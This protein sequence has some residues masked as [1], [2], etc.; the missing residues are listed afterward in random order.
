MFL[1]T[2]NVVFREHRSIE[3]GTKT[4]RYQTT[5]A[6]LKE[7][8]LVLVE[9]KYGEALAKVEGYSVCEKP[10]MLRKV[11]TKIEY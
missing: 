3:Y 2:V 9:T 11:L 4:F 8:D 7:G 10:E 1:Q 5:I 6:D